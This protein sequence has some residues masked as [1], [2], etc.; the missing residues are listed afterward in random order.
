MGA[1]EP[2]IEIIARAILELGSRLLVCRHARRGYFMLP[3]GHIEFGETAAEA[4]ER[5]MMEETGLEVR[6]RACAAVNE[7]RFV[8]KGRRRHEL[9]VVF[10]VEPVG[11]LDPDHPPTLTS[12]EDNL[13]LL[14]V[15]QAA[16]VDL[17]L[18]PPVLKAW[19]LAW[20]ENTAPRPE[21]I[22]HTEPGFRAGSD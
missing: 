15:D 9:N 2:T 7:H 1:T 8:Q 3:G 19:L 20:S 14:W 6:A 17:D 18:R 16:I 13:E 10:H 4:C 21:W 5:E 22:T 11:G 12:P